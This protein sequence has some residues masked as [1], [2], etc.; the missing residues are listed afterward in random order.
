MSK[1]KYCGD[2]TTGCILVYGKGD[3]CICGKETCKALA[4]EESDE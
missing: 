1:C 4:T 3:I 2:D